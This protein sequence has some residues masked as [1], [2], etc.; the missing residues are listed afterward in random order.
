MFAKLRCHPA[1]AES[2]LIRALCLDAKKI[3]PEGQFKYGFTELL[4][5][6]A[7]R[8]KISYSPFGVYGDKCNL[9]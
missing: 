3:P 2:F 5:M 4:R 7:V 1:V 8:K 6:I 9:F